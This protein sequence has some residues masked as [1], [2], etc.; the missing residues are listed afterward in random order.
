MA[1]QQAV[2]LQPGFI[3]Q[4]RPYRESSLLL[5][6]FT[7]DQ[8]IVSVLAKGVR[9]QK[10]SLAGVL[11]AFTQLNVSYVGRHDLKVLTQAEFVRH[12][13]LQRLALYCG[14]YVNELLQKFIYPHDAHPALFD[15]YQ[16]CLQQLAGDVSI[17]QTLRYFELGLLEESGYGVDLSCDALSGDE[18]TSERR[19]HYQT[20]VGMVEDATG[21]IS[22]ETLLCLARR[23]ELNATQLSEAKSLLRTILDH[24]LQGRTLKSREVLGNI[25]RYL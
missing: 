24:Q 18:V 1:E 4:Q 19:Y 23:G 16:S 14:F 7:R 12:F 9:K 3:L 2:Y 15:A 8:G 13:T 20:D 11:L 22:G 21:K 17:E 10:S 5:E 25:I 6:L